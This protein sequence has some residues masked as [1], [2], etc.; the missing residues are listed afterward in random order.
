MLIRR[1]TRCHDQVHPGGSAATEGS[2]G[3]EQPSTTPPDALIKSI[4]EGA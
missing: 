3:G 2:G 1:P 4:L